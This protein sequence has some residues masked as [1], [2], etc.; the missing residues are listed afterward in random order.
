MNQL[1]PTVR[2][3]SKA[4]PATGTTVD[5][6]QVG[7]IGGGVGVTFGEDLAFLGDREVEA[8]RRICS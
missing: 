7:A 3:D 5:L 8:D 6:D 1:E 2:A 4:A